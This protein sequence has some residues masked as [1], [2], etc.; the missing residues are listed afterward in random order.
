VDTTNL[1]MKLTI[2]VA[3]VRP[4]EAPKPVVVTHRAPV[5]PKGCEE[6]PAVLRAFLTAHPDVKWTAADKTEMADYFKKNPKIKPTELE[7]NNLK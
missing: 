6:D 1:G 7:T 3:E 2:P 4:P 5:R